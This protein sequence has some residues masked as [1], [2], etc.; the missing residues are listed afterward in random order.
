MDLTQKPQFAQ[1]LKTAMGAY[2]KPMPELELSVIWWDILKAYP[3]NVVAAAFAAYCDDEARFPPV[4]AGIAQRCK[5]SDGRP[6][7]EEA[8]AIALTSIDESDTVVWT[9]EIAEAFAICRTTL[10]MGD[11]VGARMAFKEA[12]QRIVSTRRSTNAPVDWHASIGWDSAKR[13]AVLSR[14]SNNG[15]L[16]APQV[17]ALL[18]NSAGP[19]QHDDKAREQIAKIKEMMARMDSEQQRESEI[20][21]DRDRN[22]TA[23]AKARMNALAAN[24]KRSDA[25]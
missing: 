14:A 8:W 25:A 1:M 4:P 7:A 17:A 23:E 18:P 10:D 22:K 12:Y 20:Y 21:A 6:G 3:L 2:G 16:A 19:T 15:L 5:T 11:E 24:Y 13:E 9:Q